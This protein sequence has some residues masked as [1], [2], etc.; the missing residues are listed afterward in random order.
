ML[1]GQNKDGHDVAQE[2]K[3]AHTVQQ[4]PRQPE[5][6]HWVIMKACHWLKQKV[7]HEIEASHWLK[8]KCIHEIEACHW[9][10]Q[11]QLERLVFS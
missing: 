9:L 6:K 3:Q 11:K 1:P 5:L 4:D 7:I 10:E 2:S 8:Q